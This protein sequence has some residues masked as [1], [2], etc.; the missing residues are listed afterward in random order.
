MRIP[1]AVLAIDRLAC[2]AP[3]ASPGVDCGN[4]YPVTGTTVEGDL[5]RAFCPSLGVGSFDLQMGSEDALRMDHRPL[6]NAC[7]RNL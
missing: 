2:L 6:E 4:Q 7:R 3:S 5:E 1:S